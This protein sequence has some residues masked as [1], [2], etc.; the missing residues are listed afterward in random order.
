MSKHDHHDHSHDI[1]PHQLMPPHEV[2]HDP[3]AGEVARVWIS[4]GA[5]SLSLHASAFGKAEPWGHVL[6]GM[7]QQVAAACAEM[8]HGTASGNFAAIRKALNDDLNK[9]A[10]AL[11]P[12]A[13][14][15]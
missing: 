7:A 13:N 15:G 9:A 6:A 10:A 14:K 2:F 4:G 1:H 11:S 8:G 12:L 5:L 3:K